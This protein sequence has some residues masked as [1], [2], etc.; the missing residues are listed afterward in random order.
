MT[1]SDHQRLLDYFSWNSCVSDE[2]KLL[3]I[4]TPKVA[5]TSLKWWFAELEGV[6]EAVK[7]LKISSETDPELVIHVSLAVDG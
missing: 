3:Y 6:A 2:R 4:A 7:Q 5:C 1:S